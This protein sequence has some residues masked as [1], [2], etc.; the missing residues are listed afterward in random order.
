M[1]VRNAMTKDIVSVKPEDTLERVLD[2]LA[3]NNISGCPVVSGK[4]V[5]GIVSQTD[6]LRL[7]DVH[8]KI[9]TP[10]SVIFPLILAAIKSEEYDRLK[11]GLKDIL[12]MKVRDFMSKKVVTISAEDDIYKA[13]RLMNKNDVD[14]LP[15]LERKKIIGVIARGDIIKALE[16]LGK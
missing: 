11:D 1:L 15:V 14:R 9:Q 10:E 6:I 12:E 13:A 16:K 2:V 7:I 5:V 8:S 4:R 3:K